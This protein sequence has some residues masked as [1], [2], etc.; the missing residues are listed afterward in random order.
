[1]FK[2]FCKN[3]LVVNGSYS[4]V[5]RD[6]LGKTEVTVSSEGKAI[7]GKGTIPRLLMVNP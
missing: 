1:M 6:K 5:D 2:V 7:E 3:L 4:P